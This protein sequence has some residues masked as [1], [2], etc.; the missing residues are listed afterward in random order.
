M[1]VLRYR[2][3]SQRNAALRPSFILS[4]CLHQQS[5]F[6]FTCEPVKT[7]FRPFADLTERL[8]PCFMDRLF[9]GHSLFEHWYIIVFL[10]VLMNTGKL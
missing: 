9:Y 5:N 4:V 10:L 7:R 2:D 3:L 1:I 6:L 8:M